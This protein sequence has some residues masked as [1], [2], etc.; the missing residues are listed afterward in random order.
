MLRDSR[1]A[2]NGRGM[3]SPHLLVVRGLRARIEQTVACGTYL[4]HQP[5]RQ[6]RLLRTVRLNES[7]YTI[8]TADNQRR[9]ALVEQ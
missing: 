1:C 9:I 6:F 4:S 7:K 2:L 5:I 8:R 3:L